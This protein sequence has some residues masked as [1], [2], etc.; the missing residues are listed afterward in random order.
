[1][2]GV[3]KMKIETNKINIRCDDNKVNVDVISE[4]EKIEI[5]VNDGDEPQ[6][7]AF[8]IFFDR[9]ESKLIIMTYKKKECLLEGEKER[10]D[11]IGC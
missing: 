7:K 4:A 8:H 5:Y 1:M 10:Y 9:L 11:Y 6:E 2:I 3:K